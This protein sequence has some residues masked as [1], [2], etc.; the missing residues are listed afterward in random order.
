M[1]TINC[2]LKISDTHIGMGTAVTPAE[3][4]VLKEIH[5][6]EADRGKYPVI[7]NPVAG[8]EAKTID[9]PYEPPREAEVLVNGRKIPAQDARQEVS[10]PRTTE[11]EFLRMK[12]KYNAMWKGDP[13]R[14]V[15]VEMFPGM[16]PRM[17]VTFKEIGLEV[18]GFEASEQDA[19]DAQG[20]AAGAA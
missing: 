14:N 6:P 18:E 19:G 4:L 15:V 17:P 16:P 8:P 5:T 13:N 12:S 11:E 9:S 10:H 20:N 2:G 3:V 1:Q 7:V